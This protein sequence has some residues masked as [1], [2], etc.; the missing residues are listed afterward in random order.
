MAG[1]NQFIPFAV[2]SGAFVLTPA[3]YAAQAAVSG[4][5]SNGVADTALCNTIFRQSTFVSA[6][7]A[8]FMADASGQNVNDDGVVS[9]F[10]KTFGIALN[11]AHYAV[12]TGTANAYVATYSPAIPAL[13]NG[14]R[15]RFR[16][17]NT[18]TGASTLNVNGIGAKPIWGAQHSALSGGE[19]VATGE[20]E[21][22]WNSALNTTGAW[23]LL[24]CT[25][26]AQQLPSGSYGATPTAGDNST[27]VATTAFVTNA[28]SA[29][30]PSSVQ[31]SV[32]NLVGWTDGLSSVS[33]YWMDEACLEDTSGN[34]KA[35]KNAA[36]A[37]N[38]ATTGANG[39]DTGTVAANSWYSDWVI[40]NPT[41]L[42]T[43]GVAALCPVLTGSTTANSAV[44]TALSSTASMRVGMP[45]FGGSL[46]AGTVVKTVDSGT[47]ITASQKA[48]ATGSGVSL[49]FVYDPV[50]PSG[51]TFKARVGTRRTDGTANKYPLNC[52]QFGRSVRFVVSSAGNVVNMISLAAG[53]QGNV[54]TPVWVNCSVSPF[55]P[56]TA[57][58]IAIVLN[59]YVGGNQIMVAPNTYYG[60]SSSSSNPPPVF[61][62]SVNIDS[63]PYV[64]QIES[65]V[66]QYA[67]SGGCVLYCNGYEDNI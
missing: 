42:T 4:G 33:N 57:S 56:P 37:I 24:E 58:H 9:N 62:N 52:R 48:T 31:G 14:L 6:A 17:I 20:V 30:A 11:L 27:K 28:V 50:M 16:A 13:Y 34:Y 39:L 15:V 43:A 12:D 64:M 40:Y 19:I 25:G 63:K 36:L 61:C 8:Q 3:A 1:T 32:K 5:F 23:V 18:N 10:E 60:S 53:A 38:Y 41:T 7:V 46:P 22:V 29:V 67:S 2:G 54:S 49:T 45:L 66:I 21:A 59:Q 47:Q 35:V 55:V 65:G 51:Y 26:G 44:V